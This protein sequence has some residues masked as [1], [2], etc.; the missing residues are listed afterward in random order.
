MN[1]NETEKL[2]EILRSSKKTVVFSGA[3]ISC[4][5]GIPDF[6]SSDGLY[7]QKSGTRYSPEEI[8]SHSFFLRNPKEFYSFY[9][10]K[11]LY[12]DA[13]PNDAHRFIASLESANRA[14]TVVTQN[15]DGLHSAAGSSHVCE[16]HG[17]V[18]R[19]HCIRCG[20]FFSL[21]DYS[22]AL[23]ADGIPRCTCKGIIKPDVVLYEEALDDDVIEDAVSAISDA[24]TLIIIGTSL[25]V[26]PA[27]SFIRYFRGEHLILINKSETSCD[28]D[29]ELVFHEDVIDVFHALS[30]QPL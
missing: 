17:S 21:A 9:N 19:N 7:S 30:A 24:D 12:P 23:D 16:L 20:R 11:M 1:R 8:I 22:A 3:G 15:I 10:S 28:S 14:V 27:A 2:G 5:S 25:V 6:R 18:Q 29:A 4:P 26:Y 13:K